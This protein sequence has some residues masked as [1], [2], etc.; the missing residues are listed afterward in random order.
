MNDTYENN[1]TTA[2]VPSAATDGEQ[3]SGKIPTKSIA[4]EPGKN[5]TDE[6]IMRDHL[7]EIQRINQLNDPSFLHTV[8]MV[9]L[10]CNYTNGCCLPLDDGEEVK[11]PQYTSRSISKSFIPQYVS[12]SGNTKRPDDHP[13]VLDDRLSLMPRGSFEFL[14]VRQYRT[15]SYHSAELYYKRSSSRSFGTKSFPW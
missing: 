1:K 14:I 2:P 6:E 3:P 12:Y 9:K 10:C 7:R 13:K 8:S 4:D 5:K 15:N 11:C